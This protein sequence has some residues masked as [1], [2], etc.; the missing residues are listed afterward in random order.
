[1]VTDGGDDAVIVSDVLLLKDLKKQQDMW[2]EGAR[3]ARTALYFAGC[4]G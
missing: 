4:A 1:M 2:S 3:L